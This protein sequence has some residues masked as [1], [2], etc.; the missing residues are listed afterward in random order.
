MSRIVQRVHNRHLQLSGNF[1]D[2]EVRRCGSL[3]AVLGYE[4]VFL[5]FIIEAIRSDALT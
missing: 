1:P 2:E 5:L 4:S 3:G